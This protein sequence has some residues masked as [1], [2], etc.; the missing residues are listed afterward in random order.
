[1]KLEVM[2]RGVAAM[3]CCAVLM[4]GMPVGALAEGEGDG[5]ELTQTLEVQ[6]P[7]TQT[8]AS[9]EKFALRCELLEG[10]LCVSVNGGSAL[11]VLVRVL[12]EKGESVGK[13]TVN[14]GSGTVFFNDLTPGVYT[15][16]AAYTDSEAAKAV[17]AVSKTV[18]II[19][20][21]AAR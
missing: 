4:A 15:V 3:L 13:Q 20:P 14:K 7:E 8:E 10:S 1:M 16:S 2:K 21:E 19:D 5:A 18:E 12:N 17:S 9:Y 6:M 11:D